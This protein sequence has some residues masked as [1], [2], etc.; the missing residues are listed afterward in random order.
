MDADEVSEGLQLF[1]AQIAAEYSPV[2]QKN[3]ILILK[4]ELTLIIVDLFSVNNS[5]IISWIS[6]CWRSGLTV[7]K[8]FRFKTFS[9][10]VLSGMK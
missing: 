7:R 1:D 5:C 10:V 2:H 4:C 3:F 9:G 6:F 8:K